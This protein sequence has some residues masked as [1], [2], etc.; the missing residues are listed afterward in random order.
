M[1]CVMPCAASSTTT[2]RLYAGTPSLRRMTTSSAAPSKRPA[3][4]S[5]MTNRSP[6]LRNRKCRWSTFGAASS[7]EPRV[8]QLAT[9]ARVGIRFWELAVRC[10]RGFA[11]LAPTAVALVDAATPLQVAI[12]S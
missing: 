1:T 9:G 12:A 8:R 7:R 2:A 6:S 4:R 5:S 3:I 11:D 10:L